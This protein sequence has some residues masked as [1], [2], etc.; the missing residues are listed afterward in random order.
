MPQCYYCQ[1]FFHQSC[2]GLPGNLF[3]YLKSKKDYYLCWFAKN[4]QEY[5][6]T[7]AKTRENR[8]K[9]LRTGEPL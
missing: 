4:H 8:K 3:D 6:Y 5:Q 1:R 9:N 7:D 2:L